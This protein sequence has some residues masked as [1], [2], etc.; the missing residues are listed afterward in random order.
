MTTTPRGPSSSGPS[1]GATQPNALDDTNLDD[2]DDDD[3]AERPTVAIG[4]PEM[5]RVLSGLDDRLAEAL[6]AGDIKLLRVSWLRRLRRLRRQ[7]D[8]RRLKRRQEL[9]ALKAESPFLSAEEAVALLRRGNRGVGA[10]THGWLS[11]GECDPDG[12]RLDVM[13]AALEEH[14]HIE[15]VFWDYA[16]LFQTL[17]DRER[18]PDESDAFKR[19][20]KVMADVYASAVGTTVLQSREIPPRPEAFD[21]ALCLFGLKPT[22]GEDSIRETLGC[23]GAIVAFEPTR[24][25]PVVRFASHEAALAAKR[26]GPWPELCDGVDTLYNERPYDERGWCVFENAVSYELLA[27]LRVVPR[28]REALDALPSK[29]LV[30]R[31][32]QPTEPGVAPIGQLETRVAEVVSSIERATF[33]GKGDKETVPALYREYV[34]RIVGVV[35]SVLALASGSAMA[36][37]AEPLPQV[38]APAAAPLRLAE[39]QPLLLLSWQGSGTGGGPRF[40]V[41]DA[42][43]GRVA[44]AVTGVDDAELAYD[45]CSQSLLPWRPPAAGWDAAF[46]GDAR[47]LRDLVEPARGLEE[48]ARR[49]QSESALR[50]VGE[51]AREIADR[52]ARCQ[53]IAY[54]VREVGSAVQSCVNAAATLFSQGDLTQLEAALG[55]VRAAVERLQPVALEA[56]LTAALRASGASGARRYA[57]GQLLTVCTAGGWRDAD[58]ASTGADGLGHR[59]TFLEGSGEPPATLTLHPWNHAPREL[60][61]AAY[62]AMRE[63]WTR[64]LRKQHTQIF[65]ALSGNR[66]DA[67]QQC[68]AI[69]VMGDAD[70]AGVRDVRGLSDWLH[71]LHA[72]RSLGEAITAPGAALLTAPP[73][74]GKTTLISQVVVLALDCAEL[75]PIVIKVQLLQ[76]KLRDAPD[77]FTSHWNWVDAYLC[78]TYAERPEVYRM[79]RQAMMARRALLLLDGLDEAGAKRA[80]IEQHVV[81]VLAHQG[82]VMLCTSRPAGVVEARFSGFRLLKLAPLTEAQQEQAL[83]QRLGNEGDVRQLMAFVERMPTSTDPAAPTMQH[84]VTANP[85]MLSMVASVFE[86]RKGLGM[87]K[88]VVE[89]YASASDAMLAR[90]GVV[91]AEVRTLLE[92]VFFEAHV[93][94]ARVITDVQLLRGA[95]GAFAPPGTLADLDAKVVYPFQTFKGRAEEGHYVELLDGKGKGQRGVI[96]DIYKTS[97]SIHYRVKLEDGATIERLEPEQL[98]SSGLDKA[99]CRAQMARADAASHPALDG[100]VQALRDEERAAVAEVRERVGQDRLPLLS[101]LQ[102]EPLQM[103]SA[104]L[105]FQEF[106]AAQAICSGKYRLPEGSPPPWQWPAFW[107]NVVMLGNE[108]GDAFGKGLKQTAGGVGDELDLSQKLI[109]GDR[110]TMVAVVVQLMHGLASLGLRE[111]KLTHGESVKMVEALK[112]NTT[113][114]QLDL[115]RNDLGAESGKAMVEALKTN[116]TLRIVALDGDVLSIAELTSAASIVLSRKRLGDASGLVITHLITSN[117]SLTQMSLNGNWLG[118]AGGCALAVALQTNTM[119]TQLDLGDNR[120]HAESGKAMVEVL[121]TNTTLRIVAL[122]GDVLSIA[123]LTSA[124]SIVLSE[125]RLGDASGLVIAHLISRNWS[126]TQLDLGGNRLGAESGKALAVAL[127][128]NTT[129]TQLSLNHNNLGDSG[130]CALAVALQTNTTLTQLDLGGSSLGAES[131]KALAVALQTNTTLT[132]L[133]LNHNNLGDSGGCALAVALQTNTTLRHLDLGGNNLSTERDKAV[134][135]LLK[136]NSSF[137]TIACGGV[138]LSIVELTSAASIVLSEKRLGDAFGLVIAHLISR[139]RSLTQLDLGGNNLST[140]TCKALVEVLKT[141]TALAQLSLRSNQLGDADGRTLAIE[142]SRNRSLTQLDLGGNSLGAESGKALAVALQTNTTLTQLS[143]NNSRLCDAGGCALAVAL[144]TNTTLT[145]LDLGGNQLGTESGKAVVE[146]LKTNTT[147]MQLSLKYSTLGDAGG[148][149][150]AVALQTNTTLTQLDL[151][152]NQLG[153]ESGKALAVMLQTNTTLTQL[154]LNHNTLGDAGGCALAVALQT[155]TTLTQ[156]DL[157]GNQLGTESG[158]AVVEMLKTNTTLHMI[159][160]DGDVLSIV[161]LTSS[162]SVVLSGKRLGDASG[163]MIAHLISGN[164][165]LTQLD[166]GG[167]RLCTGICKALVEM[168]K[169]N[170]TLTQLSLNHNNLGDAAGYWLAVVLQ[171]NTTLTQLDFGGNQLGTES[172][173]A[174]EEVLKTNTTLTQLS[175]NHNNLGD[176]GGCALAVALQTNTT[177]TQLDLGGNELRTESGKALAVALQTNTTLTQLSLIRNNLGDAGGC[178]LAV[179]LQTNTTLTQLDLGGNQ[180]GTESGKALAVAL[181]TNT[182]LTQ[183]DLGDNQLGT[184]SGKAMVEALKTN[185]KLAQLSLNKNQLED[186]VGCLLAVVLQTNTTL[187][188]L[189]LNNNK[190]GDAGGCAL[191]VALQTNMTLTQLD[192]GSNQLGTESGK[193]M[194]EVLKT[195]T[196]LAQLSL[197]YNKLGYAVGYWLAVVLQTNTTLTQLDLGGNQLGTESGKAVV[198]MLKKNTTLKKLNLVFN[199]CGLDGIGLNAGSS[200]AVVEMLK[201]HT[202]L[203]MIALEGNFIS[204]AELTSAA[205]IVLSGKR[206]GDASGLMIAHLISGNRSLTQLD[207]GGNRLCTG[208]CKALVEM[209]KTNTTLAKLSLSSNQLGDAGCCSLAVALQTNTTLTQLD[210]GGN[211]LGTESGKAMVEVL[212]TNTTMTQLSLNHNTLGDAGGCALA[213]ALQTNTTLTQLDLGGNQ[214]GTESGKAVVEALK[215]NTTLHMIALDGD[216]LSIAELTSAASIVLSG[217]RLGDASGLVIAH[218]ISGNRSLTQLDL[219]GNQLGTESG[220]ALVEVLKTNTTLHM[221]ALDGDV[222]SIAELTSAASIVLSGKRLG[223]ASGLVIAYLITRN[224]S[225]TQLDLGGNSLGAESSQALAVALQ[226]N[227]TLTQLSL[228]SNKLGDAGGLAFA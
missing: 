126:L 3:D 90:G 38:D 60:P 13:L 12:A 155:N 95:L 147:L 129:L 214:L 122:D 69:E 61:H 223:D 64:E 165:S 107:A 71:S 137:H 63:W 198:E 186:A 9:E 106:F 169:T 49:M 37:P 140:E 149:A 110:P 189:S 133:S 135:K 139:N 178:A 97:H 190:L 124:A 159:A 59:L 74:A 45:R 15:G 154:S 104:H 70:L 131:G 2:I 192:L 32:G 202:T 173:K 84:R 193:A 35:T 103:Q 220:K 81:K 58:V 152:G 191:A 82:H 28:V 167:N 111:N 119:L 25:P 141:N 115:G 54:A 172:G 160:L 76:A 228:N 187:T 72:A 161:E 163:L 212:K 89:L 114:T 156:L 78:L 11:P 183:L 207:L 67:L 8:G 94:Q 181:Q 222:L 88:T 50:A 185:T 113:L 215:T 120:L 92:V 217:K 116:T 51:R 108:M 42:T 34:G 226:T 21:G 75:V 203:H 86:I 85:L 151:G 19:A 148:C 224:R 16:S 132:Q 205:S 41:V 176:A 184:E 62:E 195:N 182:T 206:L 7:P 68:V 33:T 112:T 199:Q 24:N 153:T 18:T 194:V 77:A 227:T 136:M 73:A 22:T 39:G 127:Q 29:V 17:P 4:P 99:A 200:K 121:K 174:M 80:E 40:G 31:S 143:L 36:A 175:L 57:A 162:A 101:L 14:L 65:D 117:R 170:T 179:A 177:L 48:D 168:L 150:L 146:M 171:T 166:L 98:A 53:S 91:T 196:M 27:R 164:R 1:V 52:A 180:L 130:G 26:A 93:A 105:S 211:Q 128:T 55:T 47:A 144:Q 158:T 44:A 225:L 142:I 56:A 123:E 216:V 138:V 221:I 87:P 30:L 208:T 43:G 79:L 20:I 46:V 5:I 118:D 134:L 213:V 66:L 83:L 201:T 6:R 218:L 23:F 100:A 10:L 145:Q 109:G 210:L 157:G 96:D 209:L 204:I 188:Q 197:N 125:K 219:G 102:V